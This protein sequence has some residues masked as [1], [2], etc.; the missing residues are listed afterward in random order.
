MLT[1]GFS[2]QG[3]SLKLLRSQERG[4]ITRINALRDITTQ[5]LRKMGITPGQSIAIEQRF[6]RFIVR[7]G[8]TLHTLDDSAIAAIYVRIIER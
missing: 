7:V 3:S 8:N 1:T 2:V 4:V 6:P 5:N